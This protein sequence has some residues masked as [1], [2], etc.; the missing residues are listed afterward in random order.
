MNIILISWNRKLHNKRIQLQVLQGHLNPPDPC[1]GPGLGPAL[2]PKEPQG[3]FCITTPRPSFRSCSS[4]SASSRYRSMASLSSTSPF[5]DDPLHSETGVFSFFACASEGSECVWSRFS[6][7][8][9]RLASP[10]TGSSGGV[11]DIGDMRMVLR[12][13]KMCGVV[14]RVVVGRLFNRHSSIASNRN[15][16][17]IPI[18]VSPLRSR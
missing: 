16:K 8:S 14:L 7:R 5:C 2:C 13:C 11:F 17:A 6:A 10:S 4:H 12:V 9:T 15:R 3:N 18:R 1:C